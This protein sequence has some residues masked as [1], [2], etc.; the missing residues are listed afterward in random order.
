[1][2]SRLTGR[3]DAVRARGR[4]VLSGCIWH[5][6][7][8][9]RFCSRVF[10]SNFKSVNGHMLRGF[11]RANGGAHGWYCSAC[12]ESCPH[13]GAVEADPKKPPRTGDRMV[14]KKALAKALRRRG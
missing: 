14:F 11:R 13:C 1:M 2:T 10:L 6:Y 12:V 9:K 3:M 4:S 8:C 7:G 5:P